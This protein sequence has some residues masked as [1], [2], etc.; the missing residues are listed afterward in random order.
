MFWVT[1][2]CQSR[3]SILSCS[4]RPLR[5]PLQSS[6]HHPMSV[7]DNSPRLLSG[8][9]NRR[10]S[11]SAS[12]LRSKVR[13][14]INIHLQ[15]QWDAHRPIM[16]DGN[17]PT[18][19]DTVSAHLFLISCSLVSLISCLNYNTKKRTVWK[20]F[21]SWLAVKLTQTVS[22]HSNNELTLLFCKPH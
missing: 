14:I 15:S 2:R 1:T 9:T 19:M 4:A 10:R 21:I 5:P 17:H 18:M 16:L 22:K 12:H 11:T 7:R 20:N 3:R 13:R 8:G 6:G